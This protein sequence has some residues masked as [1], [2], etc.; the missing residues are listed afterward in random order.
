MNE[1]LQG[2]LN[3]IGIDVQGK[4]GYRGFKDILDDICNKWNTLSSSTKKRIASAMA[5]Y[6]AEDDWA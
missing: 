2:L 6:T 4:E 5:G 3:G 1:Y